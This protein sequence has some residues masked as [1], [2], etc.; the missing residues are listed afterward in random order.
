MTAANRVATFV[1]IKL[2]RGRGRRATMD[3]FSGGAEASVPSSDSAINNLARAYYWQRLLDEG[4]VSS[5]AEIAER[6]GLHVSTVNEVLRLALMDPHLVEQI[7]LGNGAVATGFEPTLKT[8]G[9]CWISNNERCCVHKHCR[10]G[11]MKPQP[12]SAQLD[13]AFIRACAI[14]ACAH[15]TP[16]VAPASILRKALSSLD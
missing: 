15:P 2:N 8:P 5:G 4:H 10:I 12:H 1:P 3:R 9:L 6:E 13:Y 11:R 7:L 16:C 14:G